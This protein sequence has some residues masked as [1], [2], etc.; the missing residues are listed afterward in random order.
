VAVAAGHV[1]DLRCRGEGVVPARGRNAQ[2][3]ARLRDVQLHDVRVR[4]ER[5]AQPLTLGIERHVDAGSSLLRD[6][7]AVPVVGSSSRHRTG[8]REPAARGAPRHRGV[9]QLDPRRR[10]R[11]GAVFV[12]LR[13]PRR[14][15]VG[16]RKGRPVLPVR[17]DELAVDTLG[18]ERLLQPS[19]A[20]TP[21]QRDRAH[22]GAE[23]LGG[24]RDVETLAA[25]DL[26][27][28]RR[29]VDVA[30]HESFDLEQSIDRGIR[31]EADDHRPTIP[32]CPGSFSSRATS[33]NNTST[34]S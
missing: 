30:L 18:R 28:A 11:D 16:D 6:Q 15:P 8:D 24:A 17:P 34:R 14:L 9:G 5:D 19:P 23:G 10:R 2:E 4:G 20:V 26:H 13:E 31:G 22:V 1:P 27:E 7:I 32:A 33:P 3:L 25:G 29:P 12:E 21:Q